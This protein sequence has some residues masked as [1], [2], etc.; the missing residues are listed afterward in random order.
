V[1]AKPRLFYG[2]RYISF[3]V[4]DD[5]DDDSA[6]ADFI[7]IPTSKVAGGRFSTEGPAPGARVTLS[8]LEFHFPDSLNV[9]G[10]EDMELTLELQDPAAG[11]NL[12]EWL[13]EDPDAE[14]PPRVGQTQ[15]GAETTPNGPDGGQ[16]TIY[17]SMHPR[18]RS[19]PAVGSVTAAFSS[20]CPAW[21]R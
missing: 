21:R 6:E 5:M 7:D 15:R 18:P 1:G 11:D 9:P 8:L 19:S 4:R 2:R 14:R 12:M 3:E 17:A 13:Q 16:R 10:D 20:K